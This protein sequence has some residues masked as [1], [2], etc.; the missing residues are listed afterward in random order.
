MVALAWLLHQPAVT[1]PIVGPRTLS[2]LTGA[3]RALEI[4]LDEKASGGSTRS[5]PAR[6][7]QPPKR[8]LVSLPGSATQVAGLPCNSDISPGRRASGAVI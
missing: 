2:Q 4:T 3:L 1:A 7:A 8:T 6:A 5:S